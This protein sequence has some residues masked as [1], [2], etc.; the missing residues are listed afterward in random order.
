MWL[1][2]DRNVVSQRPSPNRT[3]QHRVHGDEWDDN[4]TN[5]QQEVDVDRQNPAN[6]HRPVVYDDNNERR[7]CNNEHHPIRIRYRRQPIEL[8]ALDEDY[9]DD[10]DDNQSEYA[11]AA[12]HAHHALVAPNRQRRPLDEEQ[13][14]VAEV[15]QSAPAEEVE[16]LEASNQEESEEE[17]ALAQYHLQAFDEAVLHQE[18]NRPEAHGVEAGAV[19]IPEG[20]AILDADGQDPD[21]IDLIPAVGHAAP[22]GYRNPNF[23]GHHHAYRNPHLVEHQN[24]VPNLP[25]DRGVVPPIPVIDRRQY[26]RLSS[27]VSRYVRNGLNRQR[28]FAERRLRTPW[29][30]ASRAFGSN[31]NNRNNNAAAGNS[32]ANSVAASGQHATSNMLTVESVAMKTFQAY[33]PSDRRTYSCVHCQAHLANHDELI[34]KSFQGS[35]GKAYLFNSVVNVRCGPAEERVLLTGLHAV[36]D[37]ACENCK[38]TLGWKYEH[39]FESSQKYKEGKYIIELAHMIKDNG[40]DNER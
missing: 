29:L 36:A 30:F 5:Q 21:F 12:N 15:D 22:P 38:T 16:A 18:D 19:A 34:S 6:Q 32:V 23:I 25:P 2:R 31:S 35:Q 37:I 39:A 11:A 8:L 24:I 17:G 40:W 27:R 1:R 20:Q 9:D 7:N 4:P 28:A 33:L 13:L 10:E 3:Y 26:F 14:I